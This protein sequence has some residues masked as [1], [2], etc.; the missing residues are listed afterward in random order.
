M[1]SFL[2]TVAEDEAVGDTAD[3][4]R[5]QPGGVTNA[6]RTFGLRPAAYEAWER[7]RDAVV[8]PMG[9]RRYELA[10]L[11]AAVALRSSYC[12]LAHGQL[13]ANR[14]LPPD[15]VRD[16]AV[17]PAVAAVDEQERAVVAFAGRVAA[18]PAG[19]TAADVQALREL[20]L[21]DADV[22]DVVLA[23]ATRCFFST[24]LDATGTL[25]D[26]AFGALEPAGL[27]D[28]LVVGRAIATH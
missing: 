8:G 19:I 26:A 23:A 22:L 21:A 28:A 24:V 9:L 16:L 13:L 5:E 14:F 7:L 25:P 11:G 10:T 12:S 18:D 6:V 15:V 2:R 20:G 27:R 1:S 17:D 3:L 4:Y